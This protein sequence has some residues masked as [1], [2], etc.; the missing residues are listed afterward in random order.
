MVSFENI[1][2]EKFLYDTVLEIEKYKIT[3]PEELYAKIDTFITE[4]I[5]SIAE[6]PNFWQELHKSEF[7]EINQEGCFEINSEE[8]LDA[9]CVL[10]MKKIF[11]LNQKVD[12][13]AFKEL[14][15]YLI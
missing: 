4:N 9:I 2:N 5:V 7:G 6:E 11:E 8:S 12:A 10:F 15:P 3:M 1:E 13:F 14:R